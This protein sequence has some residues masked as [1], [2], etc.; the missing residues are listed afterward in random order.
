MSLGDLAA[1]VVSPSDAR[2]EIHYILDASHHLE[3]MA[4]YWFVG[5][6]ALRRH[7]NLRYNRSKTADIFKVY[8][9]TVPY[10]TRREATS[11]RAIVFVQHLLLWD[12]P[13]K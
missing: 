10:R 8:N 1:S 3:C 7:R 2:G 6:P 11:T 12:W 13:T 9:S 5:E 4:E